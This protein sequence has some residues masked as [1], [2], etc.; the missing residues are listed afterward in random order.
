MKTFVRTSCMFPVRISCFNEGIFYSY[1]I[2]L[3]VMVGDFTNDVIYTIFSFVVVQP[4]RFIVPR[5]Q[6]LLSFFQI[7]SWDMKSFFADLLSVFFLNAKHPVRKL[8]FDV[9]NLQA[10]QMESNF[11]VLFHHLLWLNWSEYLVMCQL[12]AP[13]HQE[14]VRNFYE[15]NRL[16]MIIRVL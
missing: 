16:N 13:Q 5:R 11:L 8:F 14:L 12:L 1:V 10:S 9:F 15:N 7:F 6:K 4:G 3:V 2:Q